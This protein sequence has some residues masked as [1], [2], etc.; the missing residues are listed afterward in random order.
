MAN[1]VFEVGVSQPA[2][3]LLAIRDDV[4]GWKTQVNVFLIA[5]YNQN[6]HPTSDSWWIQLSFCDIHAPVPSPPPTAADGY[7]ACIIAICGRASDY[8][9]PLSPRQHTIASKYDLESPYFASLPPAT[10]SRPYSSFAA[11]VAI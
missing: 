8:Q 7:P 6:M 1:H 11:D 10:N 4:L 3:Q 9:W 2:T 5:V